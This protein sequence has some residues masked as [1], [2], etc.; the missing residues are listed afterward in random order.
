MSIP[1]CAFL[2]YLYHVYVYPSRMILRIPLSEICYRL[3]KSCLS[4]KYFW[5]YRRQTMHCPVSTSFKE[6][7]IGNTPKTF[8]WL[9]P[10]KTFSSIPLNIKKTLSETK[11]TLQKSVKNE[12]FQRYCSLIKGLSKIKHW[13]KIP[14]IKYL[15]PSNVTYE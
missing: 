1:Y 3:L 4:C 7:K 6:E 8:I 9:K 15:S 5:S 11:I 12:Y 14:N 13:P 2:V 10:F